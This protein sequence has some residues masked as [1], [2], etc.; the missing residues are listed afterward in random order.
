M[1]LQTSVDTIYQPIGDPRIAQVNGVILINTSRGALIE[2]EDKNIAELADEYIEIPK[3]PN[4]LTP[5]TYVIPLQMF[6]HYM[7]L[8]RGYDPDKPR[9][10]AKSVTVE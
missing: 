5:I 10:L 7:A 2:E 1:L 9:N 3:V 8:E 4:I 6:A